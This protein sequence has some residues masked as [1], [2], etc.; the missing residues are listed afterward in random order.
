MGAD[1]TIIQAAKLAYTPPKPDYTGYVKMMGAVSKFIGAKQQLANE[2]ETKLHD[3]EQDDFSGIN[4]TILTEDNVAYLESLRDNMYGAIKTM[5]NSLPGTKQYREAQKI[6]N[7]GLNNLNQLKNDAQVYTDYSKV[8]RENKHLISDY[9]S[10]LDQ[11]FLY[12]MVSEPDVINQ[13]IKFTF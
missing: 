5:K 8:V 4:S 7:D 11:S 3:F 6:Y 10:G 2:Q 12:S 13:S 9:Q 1:Q